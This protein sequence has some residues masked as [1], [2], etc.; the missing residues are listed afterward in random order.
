MTFL[1]LVRSAKISFDIISR[2]N[3]FVTLSKNVVSTDLKEKINYKE[4]DLDK[5]R[6]RLYYQS[7]KRGILEN[8]IIFGDFADDILKKLSPKQLEEYDKLI[9]G[10]TNEWDLFYYVSGRKE[11]PKDIAETSVFPIIKKYVSEKEGM[12]N[13]N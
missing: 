7:K 11:A 10:D 5:W 12:K 1:R 2:R 9:N 8:D 13:Q 3:L 4:L 6:A